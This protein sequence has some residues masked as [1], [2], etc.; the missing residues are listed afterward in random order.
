VLAPTTIYV[1]LLAL[2]PSA[3]CEFELTSEFDAAPATLFP[4]LSEGDKI[5]WLGPFEVVEKGP[6]HP[7]GVGSVRE[8]RIFGFVVRE[9]VT[10]YDPPT[11]LRYAVME[12]PNIRR[13][14]ASMRLFETPEGGS[15][16]SWSVEFDST[17]SNPQ[18]HCRFVKRYLSRRLGRLH[19][20]L[21]RDQK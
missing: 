18:R 19:R 15:R 13:H 1:L 4:Y 12:S 14:R 21:R 3:R 20:Q 7:F 9:R 16:L 8:V 6:V 11:T 10:D 17:K 2:P 5:R